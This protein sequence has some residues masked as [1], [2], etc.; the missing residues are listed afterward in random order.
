MNP[1]EVVRAV[2]AADNGRDI[3]AYRALLWDDYTARVHGEVTATSAEAECSDL[4]RN[5]R[6][7]SDVRVVET[8]IWDA[9]GA[10]TLLYRMQGTNDGELNG[11]PAT[12]RKVDLAG[13][14]ILEVEG[15][16]V[17]RTHRYVDV[18]GM[19]RQLGLIPGG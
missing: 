10:V 8:D 12:G 13:C 14:T 15:E 16:R 5:W 9:D 2:L 19:M 4:E 11:A 6:T 3:E 17:R 18:L 1:I 7:F